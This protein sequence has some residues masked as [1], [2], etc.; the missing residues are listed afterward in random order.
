MVAYPKDLGGRKAR[1]GGVR[2]NLQQ[3]FIAHPLGDLLALLA[4]TLV[5]PE[6]SGTDYPILPIQHD[7]PVHLA[8]QPNP[9]DIL[10]I[11]SRSF[12]DFPDRGKRRFLPVEWVLLRPSVLRLGQGVFLGG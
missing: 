7:Q 5:T 9:P 11:Y 1:K 10:R 3:A 12:D 2:G 8:G 6:D 4:G